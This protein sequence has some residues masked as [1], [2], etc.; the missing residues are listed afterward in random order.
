MLR[1]GQFFAC[2]THMKSR[3]IIVTGAGGFLGRY[4]AR[5]LSSSGVKVIGLGHDSWRGENPKDWGVRHW[6]SGP[7]SLKN[8]EELTRQAIGLGSLEGIV[9][10]AGGS[11]VGYSLAHPY[12]DFISTVG[13]LADVLEFARRRNPPVKIVYPSS[14]AVYGESIPPLREDQPAAPISPYG[15]HKYIAEELCRSYGIHF[16]VPSSVVRFFS[17]YGC[18]LRKQLI[19]DACV[20]ANSGD[21]NFF[22]T[23]RECRDWLHVEDAVRLLSV[24]MDHATEKCLVVNGASGVGVS[25]FELLSLLGRFLSPSR[26]PSFS[27]SERTGDPNFLVAS[28]EKSLQLGFVAKINLENGLK[29]YVEWFSS[30]S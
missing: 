22:G 29:D 26:M 7:V 30:Q 24:A 3:V 1:T 6:L 28:V 11:S 21:F 16:G 25:N 23:G 12:E 27:N 8:L 19:W 13:S 5:N 9:H 14:A 18:F 10:C 2:V 4:A 20:K 17:L 15:I